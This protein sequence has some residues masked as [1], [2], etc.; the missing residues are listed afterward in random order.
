MKRKIKE[1]RKKERGATEEQ[2]NL[3]LVIPTIKNRH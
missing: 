1:N 2:Y 3:I